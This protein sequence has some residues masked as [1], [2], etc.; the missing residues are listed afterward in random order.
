MR[1]TH[2]KTTSNVSTPTVKRRGK[3]RAVSF[4]SFL[5]LRDNQ[6]NLICIQR[7]KKP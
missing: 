3:L 7:L 2:D 1:Q 6:V 4:P 5:T